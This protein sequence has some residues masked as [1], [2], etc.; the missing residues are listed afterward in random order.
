MKLY[1]LLVAGVNPNDEKVY[2]YSREYEL[3]SFAFFNR[4]PI[5]GC[6]KFIGRETTPLLEKGTRH[7]AEHSSSEASFI[8][9]IQ[10]SYSSK[11]AYYAFC[12]SSYPKRVAFKCLNEFM[13]AFEAKHGDTWTKYI[14]DENLLCGLSVLLKDYADPTKKDVLTDA[15]KNA[16]DIKSV[17]HMNITRL[18]EKQGDLEKLVEKSKDL[19]DQGKLFLKS[20]RKMNKGWCCF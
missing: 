15:M 7:T 13:E 2:I 5:K 4:N 8:V 11:L 12:D 16:D 10:V 9:H 18:L 20:S 3:S 14:K 1:G 19:S 6:F 17:L